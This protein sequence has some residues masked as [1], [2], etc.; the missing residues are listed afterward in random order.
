MF[1]ARLCGATDTIDCEHVLKSKWARIGPVSATHLGFV[2]FLAVAIW[3]AVIGPPNRAGRYWH[4]VALAWVGLGLCASLFYVAVMAFVLDF[5]CTWCLAAHVLNGLIV[6]FT[7]LSWPRGAANGG[8][9]YPSTARALGTLGGTASLVL[10]LV[11]G[12][13]AASS[14]AQLSRCANLYQDIANDPVYIEFKTSQSPQFEIAIR[15]D[16]PAF[17]SPDAAH[18]LTAFVDFACP[19][20]RLLQRYAPDLARAFEDHLRIVFKHFPAASECNP[21]IPQRGKP[22]SCLAALAAEAARAVA[23]PEQHAAFCRAVFRAG[24]MMSDRAYVEFATQVKIDSGAYKS[25]LSAETGRD[26]ID[27]DIA[28]G[29][30]VGVNGAGVIFFDG[31]RMPNWYMS[32]PRSQGQIDKAATVALWERLLGV[33]AKRPSTRPADEGAET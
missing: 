19:H 3:N 32:K 11:L 18:T 23:T 30:R 21:H 1:G 9:S 24:P 5:W 13:V 17:G 16:D 20:C 15:E 33:A 25:A 29:Y 12:L 10:I 2:Y 7:V 26:R 14:L 6:L 27:E 8:G 31:R 4:V 28:E 22:G